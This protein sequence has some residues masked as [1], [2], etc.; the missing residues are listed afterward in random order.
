MTKRRPS[1]HI[2]RPDV[3]KAKNE[4][5]LPT[6]LP[7]K[8]STIRPKKPKSKRNPPV[9]EEVAADLSKDPRREK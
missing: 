8:R 9:T 1:R 3:P 7:A 2:T 4:T 5:N 6:P